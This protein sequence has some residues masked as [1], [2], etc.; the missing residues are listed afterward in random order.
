MNTIYITNIL[1]KFYYNNKNGTRIFYM[2]PYMLT[3]PY[4]PNMTNWI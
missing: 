4:T 1:K 3:L 2:N